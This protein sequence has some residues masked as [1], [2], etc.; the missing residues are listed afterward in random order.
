MLDYPFNI[1]SGAFGPLP[2]EPSLNID[3]G[4]IGP[5]PVE[6]FFF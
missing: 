2:A 5:F 4:A 1:N 3:A 6:L